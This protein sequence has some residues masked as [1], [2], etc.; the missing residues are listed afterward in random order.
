MSCIGAFR[1]IYAILLS[2]QNTS[3]WIKVQNQSFYRKWAITGKKCIRSWQNIVYD[4]KINVQ[5]A[6]VI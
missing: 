2:H 3:M 4:K 6:F 5:E 1:N